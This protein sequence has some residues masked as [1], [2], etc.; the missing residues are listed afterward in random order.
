[1]ASYSILY[2][3]DLPSVIEAG[4]RSGKHKVQLSQKFQDLIDLVAMKKGLAGT[5]AY[6]DEWSRGE[7]EQRDGAPEEVANA[8]ADEIEARFDEIKKAALEGL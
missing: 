8:V 3:Q 4:G 2:W 5:D 1:M 7:A 6:L